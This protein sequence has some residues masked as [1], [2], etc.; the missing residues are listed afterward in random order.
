MHVQPATL[1]DQASISQHLP[2]LPNDAA[3][4]VGEADNRAANSTSFWPE[5]RAVGS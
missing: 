1:H 3:W 5:S 4:T 2:A